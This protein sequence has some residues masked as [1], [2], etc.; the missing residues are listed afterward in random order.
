MNWAH[1]T[2]LTQTRGN[3][4]SYRWVLALLCFFFVQGC[5]YGYTRS[6]YQGGFYT[7][8]GP[9]PDTGEVTISLLKPT[10]PND[11]TSEVEIAFHCF[12]KTCAQG[13]TN[14][15]QGGYFH[16]KLD[17]GHYIEGRMTEKEAQGTWSVS[18]KGKAC[19]GHWVSLRNP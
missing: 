13:H 7:S 8:T 15:L 16:I 9:C 5:D 1:F 10:N 19:T 14:T 11:G 18:M 4:H 12:L 3:L 17:G 2:P 6:D